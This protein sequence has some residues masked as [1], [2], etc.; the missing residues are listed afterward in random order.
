MLPMPTCQV[1]N[2]RLSVSVGE[3]SRQRDQIWAFVCSMWWNTYTGGKRI[4]IPN[5]LILGIQRN[6]TG[7]SQEINSLAGGLRIGQYIGYNIYLYIDR[8]KHIKTKTDCYNRNDFFES[9]IVGKV[10]I[11][12][13]C[14]LRQIINT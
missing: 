7:D 4:V 2:W 12:I 8:I 1:L 6:Y 5:T 13:D 14:N 9:I 11:D 3:H 10:F